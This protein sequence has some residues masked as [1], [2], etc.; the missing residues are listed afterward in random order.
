M[1]LSEVETNER[2]YGFLG[3]SYEAGVPLAM[4]GSC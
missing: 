3:Q 1:D 4:K 2:A